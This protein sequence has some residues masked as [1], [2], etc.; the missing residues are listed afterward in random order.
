M[1]IWTARHEVGEDAAELLY[2]ATYEEIKAR[3][4]AHSKR[5]TVTEWTVWDQT[6]ETK[7]DTIV[8]LLNRE[9]RPVRPTDDDESFVIVAEPDGELYRQRRTRA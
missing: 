4:S 6:I 5:G 9:W 2:A 3:I 7:K 8:A 1:K